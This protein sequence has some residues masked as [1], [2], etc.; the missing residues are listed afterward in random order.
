MKEA[1]GS[2]HLRP[3]RYDHH[4]AGRHISTVHGRA[5]D[6]HLVLRRIAIHAEKLA[7]ALSG[8]IALPPR[9]PLG[10]C[11]LGDRRPSNCTCGR[12][13]PLADGIREDFLLDRLP[14]PTHQPCPVRP[15]S[16]SANSRPRSTSATGCRSGGWPIRCRL[17]CILAQGAKKKSGRARGLSLWMPRRGKPQAEQAASS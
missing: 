12:C 8:L 11:P 14:L 10:R 15:K 17:Q 1:G 3:S 2:A 4:A 13:G 16:S 6:D 5:D 7:K 9:Q